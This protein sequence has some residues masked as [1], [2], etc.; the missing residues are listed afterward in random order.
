MKNQN[1]IDTNIS[2]S[3]EKQAYPQE[4]LNDVS[5]N[6]HYIELKVENSNENLKEISIEKTLS[7]KNE[8]NSGSNYKAKDMY[9]EGKSEIK[10][11]FNIPFEN[12]IFHTLKENFTENINEINQNND[13]IYNESK[14]GIQDDKVNIN[15]E[16]NSISNIPEKDKNNL[17]L[18][19]N[20]LNQSGEKEEVT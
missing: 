11:N 16:M 4:S 10:F 1:K 7:K 3:D 15:P 13:K 19:N 17:N 12:N 5:K 9:S 14:L 2:I 20:S 6:I 18:K 8:Q